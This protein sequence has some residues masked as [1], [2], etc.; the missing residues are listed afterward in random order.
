[1]LYKNIE[2]IPVR[3]DEITQLAAIELSLEITRAPQHGAPNMGWI[4]SI[5]EQARRRNLGV[6]LTGQL[7]NGGVSWSGGRDYIFYLFADNNWRRGLQALADSKN[8]QGW[9]WFQAIKRHL[10]VPA[11]LPLWP[12]YRR[13]FHPAKQ[14]SLSYSFPQED[15]IRRLGLDESAKVKFQPRRIDPRTERTLTLIRNGTMAGPFWQSFGA[16]YGME[17]R[18]PTADVRLLEFCAGLPGELDTFGGGTRMLIRRSMAGVL[19]DTVRWNTVR[20]GPGGRHRLQAHGLARRCGAGDLPPPSRAGSYQL[21]RHGRNEAC[22]GN[23]GAISGGEPFA[24]AFYFEGH[25]Y[26]LFS[27]CDNRRKRKQ[28]VGAAARSR[29]RAAVLCFENGAETGALRL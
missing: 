7:G 18:D 5:F 15:F 9:S 29:M 27:A 19:P 8:Y 22:L 10:M 20:G 4:V 2:H 3:A 6:M 26:G 13:F 25:Q 12:W 21:Y 14:T 11:L 17:V 1:M 28:C 23:G 24:A 16:F